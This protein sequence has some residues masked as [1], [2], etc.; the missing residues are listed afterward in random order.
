[1]KRKSSFAKDNR[2]RNLFCSREGPLNL[3]VAAASDMDTNQPIRISHPDILIH[4][5][6]KPRC[7]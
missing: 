2:T 1:M 5:V 4:L 6:Y 3:G 7:F